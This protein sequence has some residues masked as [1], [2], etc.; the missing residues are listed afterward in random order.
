MN[1]SVLAFFDEFKRKKKLPHFVILMHDNPDTD[2]LASA[3]GIKALLKKFKAD[4]T[5]YW[6][7]ELSHVQNRIFY[8]VLKVEAIKL[9]S[10][11]AAQIAADTKDSKII[12][13]D[14][15]CKFGTGNITGT[16]AFFEGR[17]PDCVIDHH[18]LQNHDCPYWNDQ[19]GSCSTMILE[20]LNHY[21]VTVDRTL[22]VALVVGLKLDT[23]DLR[24][25]VTDKDKL[26]NKE[27]MEIVDPEK[28]LK[29]INYPK[30]P[31]VIPL[32][33]S[34]YSSLRQ[35]RDLVFSY[36][37]I[38]LPEHHSQIAEIADEMLRIES[39]NH[40][41]VIAILNAGEGAIKRLSV[42]FRNTGDA[43][44]TDEFMKS[45]FGPTFGGRDGSGGGS[46]E[47]DPTLSSMIDSALSNDDKSSLDK[48]IQLL[49]DTYFERLKAEKAKLS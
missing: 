16:S 7:G 46:V 21:G 11:D 28:Y 23:D 8:N 43:I 29:I 26:A 6:H 27:L 45:V 9:K 33:A 3:M 30:P 25:N 40:C 10:E 31:S 20:L 44:H 34:V 41:C 4:S 22:A 35:E 49:N 47:L 14:I 1:E 5:I 36:A 42:S 2:A 48:I 38:I 12:V 15:S 32:R 17:T 18:G 24:K 13:V 39:I 19:T 37:G